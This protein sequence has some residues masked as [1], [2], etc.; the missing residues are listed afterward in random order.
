M[1]I[2]FA[3][4]VPQSLPNG[5]NAVVIGASGGI[6]SAI[7]DRLKTHPNIG[8]LNRLSRSHGS[9]DLLD[10]TKISAAAERLVGKSINLLVCATGV[11]TVGDRGPEKA[12]REIDPEIMLEQFRVNAIGPALVAKT[13]SASAGQASAVNRILS[14][15]ARW[16]DR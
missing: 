6:G 16:I 14:F 9:F 8:D 15:S 1:S 10:E 5:F 13:L 11:L 3:T 2:D 12:L 4:P 7:F